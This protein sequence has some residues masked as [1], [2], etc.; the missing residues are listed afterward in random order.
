MKSGDEKHP[1]GAVIHWSVR[2]PEDSQKVAFTCRSCGK[3]N[4]AS[5]L[6]VRRKNWTGD[7]K[8][9]FKRVAAR[10]NTEDEVLMSGTR[11]LWSERDDVRKTVPVV[12]GATGCGKRRDIH[13][14]MVVNRKK[15]GASGYCPTHTRHD[16]AIM[17][18]ACVGGKVK[19]QR[20]RKL[21]DT[22]LDY[23]AFVA[24]LK[25]CVIE[26]WVAA[27][28]S[29]TAV[30]QRAVLTRYHN[31]YR[32]DRI[33]ESTLKARLNSAG[34]DVKWPEFVELRLRRRPQLKSEFL[35]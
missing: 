19:R 10:K 33:A 2:H 12:C 29:V 1:S 21:G 9:C 11:V 16:L 31:K 23:D 6:D 26:G 28:C 20:G 7:C 32:G 18:H 34:Y 30:K 13:P 8:N 35:I 27:G 15:R 3:D 24:D 5:A 17:A 4:F 22:L 25:A 14:S